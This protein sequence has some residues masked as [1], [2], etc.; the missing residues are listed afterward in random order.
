MFWKVII[1]GAAVLATFAAA[2]AAPIRNIPNLASV[3]IF[4]VSGGETLFNMTPADPVVINKRPD[5]LAFGNT[6]FQSNSNEFYD[7]FY[8]DADGT[9]NPFGAFLTITAIFDNPNDGGLNISRARLISQGPGDP[10]ATIEYASFV[11][12]F[13]AIGDFAFPAT[14]TNALGDTPG[15]TTFL[16]D[17]SGQP[18]NVRLRLTLGFESTRPQDVNAPASLTLVGLGLLGAGAMRRRKR[19]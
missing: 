18:D 16:G 7:F 8:S 9:F 15:T 19:R 1:A 2:H 3:Q 6:D 12:S 11:A 10:V 5:R 14:A 4:E 17:T 13:F